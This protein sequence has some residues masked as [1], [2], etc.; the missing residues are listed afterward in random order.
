MPTLTESESDSIEFEDQRGVPQ[1]LQ[2]GIIVSML[3]QSLQQVDM[4]TVVATAERFFDDQLDYL[5]V[6]NRTTDDD[7]MSTGSNSD[8]EG[9]GNDHGFLPEE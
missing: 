8:I 6:G 5:E 3:R 2:G 1:E 7:D 9:S 4:G